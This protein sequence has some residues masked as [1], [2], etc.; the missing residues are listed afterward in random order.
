MKKMWIVKV[1]F[2]VCFLDMII[3]HTELYMH[4]VG[5]VNSSGEQLKSH[6]LFL[7]IQINYSCIQQ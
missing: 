3:S 5:E 4:I 2:F 7:E 6:D 1:L